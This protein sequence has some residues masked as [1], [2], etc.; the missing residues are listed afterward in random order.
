MYHRILA[1][2]SSRNRVI[3][4]LFFLTHNPYIHLA[5]QGGLKAC[6]QKL[7]E[8]A[9][10]G[11][12]IPYLAFTNGFIALMQPFKAPNPPKASLENTIFVFCS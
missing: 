7:P 9:T 2:C 6:V 5:G 10:H 4:G 8:P 11:I 12:T 1:G 3:A